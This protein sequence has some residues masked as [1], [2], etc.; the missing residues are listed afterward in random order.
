M[1]AVG[2][3]SLSVEVLCSPP[4]VV[5][6]SLCAVVLCSLCAVVLCSSSAVVLSSLSVALCSLCVVNYANR[7]APSHF[8]F[9]IQTIFT[10]CTRSSKDT[11]AGNSP[12]H[13]RK[14]IFL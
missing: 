2:L 4:A 12:G 1:F 3:Y 7:P 14:K 10:L 9:S 11:L 6:C 8:L 13:H 5:I